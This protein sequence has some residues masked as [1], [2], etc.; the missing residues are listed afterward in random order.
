MAEEL[1]NLL[2]RIQKDGVDKATQEKER[3]LAEAKEKAGSIISDAEVKAKE[4]IEKAE[5]DSKAFEARAEKSLDQAARDTVLSVEQAVTTA[6]NSIVASEVGNAISADEL[7]SI[8]ASVIEA[9]ASEGTAEVLVSPET[10]AKIKDYF[11]TELAGKLKSGVEI[12]A[13]NSIISGFQV[14]FADGNVQHDFTGEA[15][16]NALCQLLRP[17]LAEIVRNSQKG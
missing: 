13:D 9:Y 3:I 2:E 6:M 4:I 17:H 15:I 7:K 12:K 10:E 5:T 11:A 16:T 8:I 14:S 1:Q